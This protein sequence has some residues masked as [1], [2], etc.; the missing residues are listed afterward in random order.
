MPWVGGDLKAHPVPT[1]CHGLDAHHQTRLL[2]A[3]SNLTL[4]T[5]RDG[6][7]T[8]LWA[9]VPVPHHPLSKEF[10]PNI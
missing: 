7:P 1:P 4:S 6:A 9:A 2:R 8:A 3:P 5:S 10:L